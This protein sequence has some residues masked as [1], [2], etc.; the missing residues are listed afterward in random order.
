MGSL[1]GVYAT[2]AA[3]RDGL[4]V[5]S[6]LFDPKEIEYTTLVK[7]AKKFKCTDKVFAHSN[8]HLRIAKTL[9][10]N[11]AVLA[12]ESQKPRFAKL[13]DQKYYLA[14][15]PLKSLPMCDYQITK[16]NAAMGLKQRFDSVLSPR[17]IELAQKILEKTKSN[18][19]A[20]DKF[21]S[22]IDDNKLGA[23]TAKLEKALAK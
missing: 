13:S 9:V 4:E 12:D 6:V 2:T 20:L 21:I 14:N 17:Q 15:S 8:Q 3:W 18:P 23:Y 7:E 19:S 10:G 16:I 22:P 1:D 5:V 11:K